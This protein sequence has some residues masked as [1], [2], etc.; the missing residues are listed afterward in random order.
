MFHQILVLS[1]TGEPQP[2]KKETIRIDYSGCQTSH[3]L[4]GWRG[5]THPH[6]LA[7]DLR[8]MSNARWRLSGGMHTVVDDRDT[9][10]NERERDRIFQPLKVDLSTTEQRVELTIPQC[11]W[12]RMGSEVG[13]G[14]QGMIR[15]RKAHSCRYSGKL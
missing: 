14:F 15:C 5:P 3:T 4:H 2:E 11:R 10:V 9:I 8:Y 1:V 13:R 12:I 6:S 7:P